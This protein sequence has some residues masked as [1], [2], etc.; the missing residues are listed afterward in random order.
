METGEGIGEIGK[1][2]MAVVMSLYFMVKSSLYD[3]RW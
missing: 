2:G 1:I 3:S